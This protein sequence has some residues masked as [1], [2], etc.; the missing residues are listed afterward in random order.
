MAYAV[1]PAPTDEDLAEYM[2]EWLAR[3]LRA[4][5]TLTI[6]KSDVRSHTLTIDRRL[7][8]AQPDKGVEQ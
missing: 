5:V 7:P 3:R 1:L 8:A 2:V 4:K 6:Y